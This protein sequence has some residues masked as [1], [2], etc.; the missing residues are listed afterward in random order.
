[1]ICESFS[2][3]RLTVTR[4]LEDEGE[5]HDQLAGEGLGRGY[6]DFDT[7]MDWQ[8]EIAFAGDRAFGHVNDR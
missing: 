7:S 1:M 3:D 5:K 8:S 4:G 2:R 6:A